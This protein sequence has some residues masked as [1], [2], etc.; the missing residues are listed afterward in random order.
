MDDTTRSIIDR[1]TVIYKSP[2]EI[3]GGHK[4]TTYYNCTELSPNDFSRLAAQATGHLEHD[5][6]DVAIGIA[7]TGIFFSFAV[8]GGRQVGILRE[9]GKISGPNVTGKK[10]LVV[11]D[12]VFTGKQIKNAVELVR[13][14]GGIIVGM[15]CIIDRSGGGVGSADCPLWSAFQA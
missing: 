8:A 7:Y 6:F 4:T 12:V 14:S 5:A 10:V 13:K 1:I 2:V 9:D 15:A 11:G 3:P